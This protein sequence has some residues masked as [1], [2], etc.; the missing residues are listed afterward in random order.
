MLIGNNELITA[1]IRDIN[2]KVEA[3]I[4]STD[5]VT[6]G[7]VRLEECLIG[8]PLNIQLSSRNL[9]DCRNFKRVSGVETIH[10]QD[11]DYVIASG[12]AGA[13]PGTYQSDNGRLII[14]LPEEIPTGTKIAV[15]LDF[16]VM[17]QVAEFDF[18]RSDFMIFIN[19]NQFMGEVSGLGTYHYENTFTL[20]SNLSKIRLSLNSC[21]VKYY[22]VCVSIGEDTTYTPFTDDFDGVEVYRYGKNLFNK[23]EYELVSKYVLAA[24]GVTGSSA[25]KCVEDFIYV[26]N[27]QGQ[28]ITINHPVTEVSNTTNARTFVFYTEANASTVISG[29]AT[30]DGTVTVPANAHYMRITVPT[31]YTIDDIQIELGSEVTTYED[32]VEHTTLPVV[33]NGTIEEELYALATNTI[34]TYREAIITA[35][36]EYVENKT[37]RCV[38]QLKEITIDRT[39]ES[40]FFG[41]GIGQKA[42]IKLIDINRTQDFTTKHKFKIYFDGVL[43]SPEMRVTEVHRDENTNEL[44]I[45]TYDVLNDASNHTMAEI[46]LP[47]AYN[48]KDLL[49]RI[50]DV[51]GVGVKFPPIPEFDLSYYIPPEVSEDEEVAVVD[52][53]VGEVAI[54]ETANF[55][56][57]ETLRDVLTYIAEVTQTVYFV[58]QYNVIEF[59]RLDLE[60]SAALT[61]DRDQY[62]NLTSKDNRRLKSVCHVT[63]LGENYETPIEISGTIQ[64]VRNN[65][66]W[67]LRTDIVELVDNATN[68]FTG[69]TIGQFD[70]SWRGNY[71]VEPA[72]KLELIS[73]DGNSIF[74]YLVND[75]IYYNGFYSQRTL[76]EYSDEEAEHTNPTT[77]GEA[78]KQT[79]AKVDKANKEI[80]LLVSENSENKESIAQLQLNANSIVSSVAN[81]ESALVDATNGIN[82]ELATITDKVSATMTSEEILFEIETAIDNGVESVRTGKGFTFNDEGLT[83]EDIENPE[84]ITQITNDGMGVYRGSMSDNRRVLT[85]NN[86]G[87][88]AEDLHATTY[89]LIGKYSRLENYGSKKRTAC[90]WIG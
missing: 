33:D 70:C 41:F 47:M 22:N 44:S 84:I 18:P 15:S 61:I 79:Y 53:G 29:A 16:D 78:L 32:Y 48:L 50:G 85:A 52:E 82:Q 64:Y 86:E 81:V 26:K 51:L 8:T 89:L 60:G 14:T 35:S 83:I 73:K 45:T 9:I 30:R 38:D 31:A 71:L 2:A 58:N 21:K 69:M 56:G 72:D 66:L 23:N 54:G 7:A 36:Y 5:A 42:N 11:Y 68:Q 24:G 80:T 3:L 19:G 43:V 13:T 20:T 62:I 55:E 67:D 46:T 63:E 90:Y 77:L 10:E 49:L 40:K 6:G 12:S 87:V 76:W 25:Y 27:F 17:E 88:K 1:P 74:S 37:Y 59:K 75:T 4:V 57:T 28:T 34:F 65:P 39:G